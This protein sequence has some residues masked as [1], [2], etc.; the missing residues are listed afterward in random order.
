MKFMD[1][2]RLLP[3]AKNE[4]VKT[5]QIVHKSGDHPVQIVIPFELVSTSQIYASIA[6]LS[7]MGL[8]LA[9][10]QAEDLGTQGTPPSSE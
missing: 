1:E 6:D 5:Y 9:I 4:T 2:G 7:N 8:Y 3:F 10:E